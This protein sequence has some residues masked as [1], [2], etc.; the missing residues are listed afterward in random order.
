MKGHAGREC[1]GHD[2][3]GGRVFH[4]VRAVF[5]RVEFFFRRGL[6]RRDADAAR[7]IAAGALKLA[8]LL[9]ELRLA[10]TRGGVVQREN[11]V[12]NARDHLQP[13]ALGPAEFFDFEP[14]RALFRVVEFE[15]KFIELADFRG[16]ALGD[17]RSGGNGFFRVAFG[18]FLDQRPLVGGT[19][20]LRGIFF[21]ILQLFGDCAEGVDLDQ[22]SGGAIIQNERQAAE[23][24]A[25]RDAAGGNAD[26]QIRDR[27]CRLVN[28]RRSGHD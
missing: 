12:E 24:R 17:F 11:M 10:G 21:Q 4:A 7:G 23:Q 27:M 13:F 25:E 14:E 19:G 2:S 16:H 22:L 28:Y 18:V 1:L 20:D 8:D 9:G 3:F 15:L 5:L 26:F 6:E